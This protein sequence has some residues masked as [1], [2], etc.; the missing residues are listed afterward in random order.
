MLC[1]VLAPGTTF[2]EK[3]NV[4]FIQSNDQEAPIRDGLKFEARAF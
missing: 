4:T 1:E 3:G 2:L